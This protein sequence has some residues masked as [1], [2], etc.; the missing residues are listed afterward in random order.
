M[1]D[2]AGGNIEVL[3]DDAVYTEAPRWHDGALWFSDIGGGQVRRVCLDGR[4]EVFLSGVRTPSGLGWTRSSDLLVASIE[5]SAIYRVG[6]DRIPRL[7]CGKESHGVPGTNDMAT[8][9]SR[10]YVTC[11]GYTNE[12]GLPMEARTRPVGKILLLDH[13][14]GDCR[15]V[16]SDMKMP[17]GVAISPDGRRLVVAEAFAWRVVTFDI[18]DD[19]SLSAPCVFAEFGGLVDGLALDAEG[20]VWVGNISKFQRLDAE[21]RLAEVVEAPGWSCVAPMLGGPDGRT[22]FMAAS[23]MDDVDAIFDGRAK[24]RI[25]TTRVRVPAAAE[26]IGTW[27]RR[28]E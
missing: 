17:N 5:E 9:G 7:F 15:V 20:G 22:L 6:P 8:A 21:G 11:T 24:G 12:K 1:S 16:A 18:S 2:G 26:H 19:G 23:R 10:S 3:V 4:S 28:G 14:T 25:L 13:E 27:N